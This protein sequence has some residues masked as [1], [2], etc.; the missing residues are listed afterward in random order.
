MYT[1]T[2]AHSQRN[3]NFHSSP[4]HT[5][6]HPSIPLLPHLFRLAYSPYLFLCDVV[7]AT[8]H[9]LGIALT[10]VNATP[11]RFLFVALCAAILGLHTVAHAISIHGAKHHHA[12]HV[13]AG[14][15]KTSSSAILSERD[16]APGALA[17]ELVNNYDSDNLHVYIQTTL[18][19][20]DQKRLIT[21]DGTPYE[22]V[23]NIKYVSTPIPASA[24][25]GIKLGAKGSSVTI[26][27]PIPMLTGRIYVADGELSL[28]VLRSDS[29]ISLQ[30]PAFQEPY[31]PDFNTSFGF[32]EANQDGKCIY[33]NP[34]Y[35][36]FVGL[37]LGMELVTEKATVGIS[38]LPGNG[39]N[40]LCRQLAAEQAQ[41][42]FP[43][44]KL[45]LEDGNGAPVR[46]LSPNHDPNGFKTYFDD[47][48]D[49]VW[50]HITSNGIQFDT[51]D[52]NSLVSCHVQGEAMTCDRTS[53]PFPKPTSADIWGC[54]SGPFAQTG[55]TCW[56]KIGA[57]FCAAFHRATFLL[58][59]GDV[60]PGQEVR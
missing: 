32:V 43:W 2:N 11:M 6:F 16:D 38:G 44:G 31:D 25:C 42:G 57:R 13:G 9:S 5:S 24:N 27:M 54:N 46:V 35:V 51:Q 50:Q 56:D 34:T 53:R 47:Y 48:I 19:D 52:G 55:D 22:P 30:N 17:I 4:R 10:L 39:V 23:A 26:T 36:D 14:A 41:D 8:V 28:S 45:C 21:A 15:S 7:L 29:G 1:N 60:Q 20:S 3:P 40:E 59:G 49:K 12:H 37:P 18:A 58:P 33:V